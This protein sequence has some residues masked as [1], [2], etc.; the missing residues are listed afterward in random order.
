MTITKEYILNRETGKIE[1]HFSKE[2]YQ[3][4][5][6]E[7]KKELKSYYLFSGSRKAWVSRS[8]NNHYSAIRIA[9][10]LGFVDGGKVGER[11][12]FAEEVERQ[13]EKAQSKIERFEQ[14]AENAEK[15]AESLQGEF[16]ELRQDWSW[17]TQPNINSSAGRSFTNHR[18]RVLDR[19]NKGFE[20]YRKSEYFQEKAKTAQQTAEGVKYSDPVYLHNRIEE[21]NKNI[22]DLERKIVR[23]E[24]TNDEEWLERLLE[25]MEYEI[26]KLAFMEN[27][28]D[29]LKEGKDWIEYDSKSI[30]VGY[31]VKI[32]GHW[33]EVLKVNPKTIL[34]KV[35]EGGAKGFTL[36]RPYAEI[37]DMRIPEGWREQGKET[38]NNPFNVGDLLVSY[39]GMGNHVIYAYQVIKKT[40]KMVLVQRVNIENGKPILNSFK[41]D[42]QERKG[43]KKDRNGNIVV[44]DE[45]CYLRKWVDKEQEAT[46]AI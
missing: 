29:K 13:Q 7:Q 21:C 39:N 44:N 32:R 22:R 18:N 4:L 33:D 25:R 35:I 27:C 38:F 40:A 46:A 28:K 5:S 2:E 31:H 11:L 6:D 17:L 41:S 19:Y 12:S 14:Y 16:N 23:A 10:K 24:E 9:E 37:Q 36:T 3:S 34:S 20:E 43:V 1:L 15:R 30:K 26:D 45:C 42:R 8:K